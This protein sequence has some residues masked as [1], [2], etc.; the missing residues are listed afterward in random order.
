MRRHDLMR[1][2]SKKLCFASGVV[3]L[4]IIAMG[5]DW[6]DCDK[7]MEGVVTIA[8]VYLGAQGFAD[9]RFFGKHK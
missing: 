3:V 9:G 6:I 5:I 4:L 8:G 7:G 2:L 1:T